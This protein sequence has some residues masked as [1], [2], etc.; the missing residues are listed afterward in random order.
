MCV[1]VCVCVSTRALVCICTF[2][3]KCVKPFYHI[4]SV[5]LLTL[6]TRGKLTQSLYDV[7]CI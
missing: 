7:S 6:N 1:C 5:F 3:W 2:L 4:F